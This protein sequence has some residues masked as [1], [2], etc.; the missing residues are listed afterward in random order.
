MIERSGLGD[1]LNSVPSD[2]YTLQSKAPE[3][4]FVIA[5][6]TNAPTSKAGYV[7]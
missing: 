5:D 3:N 4:I 7:A 1:E 2:R 6:A